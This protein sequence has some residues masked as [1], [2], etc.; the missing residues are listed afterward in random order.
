MGAAIAAWQPHRG[1][2]SFD[3]AKAFDSN[4][5]IRLSIRSQARFI[6]NQEHPVYEFLD[7]PQRDGELGRLGPYRVL[8]LLG[9]GGMGA[10][11]HARD[12]RLKRHVALKMMQKKW[13]STVIGRKRFVEEARSMAAV[14]H[15]N[16]ATIFE[17][18]IH[19]GVPFMAMEML[20]GQPLDRWIKQTDQFSY[21]RVLRLAIEVARG[22]AAAH[23]CGIIHRDIKPANIW[24]E[25]PSGRA[26]ILDFGLAIAGSSFDRFS[27]RGSVLGSPAYLSPEQSQGEP[28][29]D[30]TDLYS[31]GVVL[32]QMCAG[33]LPLVAKTI[34]EQLIYNICRHPVPLQQRNPSIPAPLCDLVHRLLDKEPRNRPASARELEELLE[35]VATECETESQAA[36][37]IV[38]EEETKSSSRL[39]SDKT[40]SSRSAPGSSAPR[41]STP[42]SFTPTSMAIVAGVTAMLCLIAGAAW[43][44]SRPDL[45]PK[46]TTVREQPATLPSQ[47]RRR[48]TA[49]SLKPLELMPVNAGTRSVTAGEAARYQ[50]TIRNNAADAAHDP[51]VVN[52]EAPVVAQIITKLKSPGSARVVQPTFA[53]KFSPAQLPG[54]GQSERVEIQF[55]TGDLS[56]DDFEVS[57]ELQT[58][59]GDLIS[60]I[61]ESLTVAENLAQGELLGFE[62]L[63]T[64]AGQGADSYVASGKQQS[65]GDKPVLHTSRKGAR[66]REHTYLRFDL[67]KANVSKDDLDRCVLL[68]TVQAEGLKGQSTINVYGVRSELQE[69]W[70]ET[71][72]GALDWKTSPCRDGVGGQSFLGQ[73]TI[74]N[75]KDHLSKSPDGVRFFSEA[76]DDFIRSAPGNLVTLVLIRE[77][78]AQAA[79]RFKSKEGKPAQAPALALRPKRPQS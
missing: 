15:D 10:V 35:R 5:Y 8:E 78:A 34:P 55:L 27:G 47:Q 39:E 7:P 63:R 4:R 23:A 25:D 21:Q 29:D 28:L 12:S 66:E 30:R 32:Y 31:L 65:M 64:H 60:R 58:P 53:K 20:K 74:D 11:F 36:L 14:H 22:L 46:T 49:L 77:N 18:G 69:S 50:M 2:N 13:A 40:V 70:K 79:T 59:A 54:P 24:I 38:T 1:W 9:Q 62:L 67:S 68:L 71:G 6:M 45:P 41:S 52:A 19:R 43:W 26:K 42:K 44:S 33:R 57:F 76:L 17:V 72:E 3:P 37:K 61:N 16:V 56:P 51:R 48:V 75:F 73:F